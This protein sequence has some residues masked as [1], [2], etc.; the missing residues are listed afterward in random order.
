M[1]IET[2]SW[3]SAG[4]KRR[5]T[6][7]LVVGIRRRVKSLQVPTLRNLTTQIVEAHVQ[8]VQK[9]ELRQSLR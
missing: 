3:S 5:A 8:T 7:A 4:R 9:L 2:R 1:F 6:Q